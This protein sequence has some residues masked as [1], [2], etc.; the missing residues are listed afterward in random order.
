MKASTVASPT[1]VRHPD[2]LL[3]MKVLAIIAYFLIFLPGSMILIPWGLFL[4]TGIFTAETNYKLMIVFADISLII[5]VYFSTKPATRLRIIIEV[6]VFGLLLLP[7]IVITADWPMRTFRYFLFI[8]PFLT[9]VVLYLIS[10]GRTIVIYRK[11]KLK[12]Y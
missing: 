7:F 8:A 10:L 9:F 12:Y 2:E 5:L 1:V 4:V 6:I 11:S 3:I